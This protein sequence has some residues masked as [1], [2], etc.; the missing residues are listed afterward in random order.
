M[1]RPRISA[2]LYNKAVI[3][4]YG[5]QSL[6]KRTNFMKQLLKFALLLL[7]PVFSFPL[8]SQTADSVRNNMLGISLNPLLGGTHNETW[9]TVNYKRRLTSHRRL[10][11]EASWI[12]NNVNPSNQYFSV[13]SDTVLA[14]A[15][16]RNDK[17]VYELGAGIEWGKYERPVYLFYGVEALVHHSRRDFS[18]VQV[19]AIPREYWGYMVLPAGTYYNFSETP[20][21]NESSLPFTTRTDLVSAGLAFPVGAGFRIRR[22]I[23]VLVQCT[24]QIQWATRKETNVDL[25]KGTSSQEVSNSLNFDMQRIELVA[26]FKF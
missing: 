9:L 4:S 25:Q 20:F 10:R 24:P 1:K 26:G 19:Q 22:W 7:T 2:P 21:S 15:I 14:Y 18:A 17:A 3:G 13:Y 5:I 6:N 8:F 23:E 12:T 16:N 11:V